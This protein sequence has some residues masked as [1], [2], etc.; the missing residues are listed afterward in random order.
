MLACIAQGNSPFTAESWKECIGLALPSDE[1][2]FLA[3]CPQSMEAFDEGGGLVSVF[4]EVSDTEEYKKAS[5]NSIMGELV[6]LFS[7]W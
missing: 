5:P 4:G 6:K 1:A 2:L 7:L 3:G